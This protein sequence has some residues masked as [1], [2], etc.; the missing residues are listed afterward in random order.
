MKATLNNMMHYGCRLKYSYDCIAFDETVTRALVK[1]DNRV[2]CIF[3]L[4]KR[5]IERL[6]TMVYSAFLDEVSTS[7][8]ASIKRQAIKTAGFINTIDYGDE[9]DPGNNKVPYDLKTGKPTEVSFMTKEQFCPNN[10][11]SQSGYGARRQFLILL[12]RSDRNEIDC[13]SD[14]DL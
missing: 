2:P 13:S 1:V 14:L 3:H 7:S 9:E 4:N 10:P 8:K 12:R 6:I 11:T 5:I